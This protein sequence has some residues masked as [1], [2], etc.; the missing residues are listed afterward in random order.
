MIVARPRPAVQ[1]ARQLVLQMNRR[2]LSPLLLRT[3]RPPLRYGLL[4]ALL[5]IT[6]ETLVI[7]PLKHVAPVSSLGVVYLV[8]VVAVST[9]WGIWLGLLTALASAAA[10]NF[11]HLPPVGRLTLQD[12]RDWVA[13]AAFVAVGATTGLIADLARAR[14]AE[15]DRRRREADLASEMA[16][17]LLGGANL[18]DA[19]ATAAQRLAAALGVASAAIELGEASADERRTAFPLRRG[20]ETVATL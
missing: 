2:M 18:D 15:A 14:A 5:G 1:R 9:W 4:A 20:G 12:S 16:R 11:F 3:E 13:L 17:I 6:L 8:A 10:F 7:Y 19:L